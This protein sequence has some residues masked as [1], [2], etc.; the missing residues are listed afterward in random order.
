MAQRFAGALDRGAKV[1]TFDP[2]LSNTAARSTRWIPVKPATDLAVILAMCREIVASELHDESMIEEHTNT[3]VDALKDHLEPYTLEWAARES[4]VP[5]GRIRSLAVEYGTTKPGICVSFRGA[6][7]HH[8]GVQTQRAIYL[9]QALT[10]NLDPG[11]GM[12][13]PPRWRYPFAFPEGEPKNLDVFNGEP[14]AYSY[15]IYGVSHQILSMID[16]GPERP[17]IYMTYCHNP[18]YANGDCRDNERVFS[19][20]EKIPFLVAIDVTLSETSLLADLVL[21]DAT[22]LERWTCDGRPSPE[23]V[24]EYQLRQPMHPPRGEA[25]NFCDVA[26]QL[27]ERL[28]FEI[29]FGTAEEFV[30]ETCNATPGVKEAGGFEYMRAHGLWSDPDAEPMKVPPRPMEL[31]S[32][33]LAEAGFSALPGW[34]AA[35]E[36]EA[37]ADDELVLITFK[38]AVQTHSRTQ[39]CKWLTEL[40]HSNPAWIHPETAAARGIRNGDRIVVRSE[41]G[42]IVTTARVT[43]GIH[44]GAI[45]VSHHCGHWGHGAYAS[46][47][48]SHVH[49][50]EPDSRLKWWEDNGVHPNLIIPNRGD[51]IAGAMC[52]NDTVVTVTKT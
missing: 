51:P 3:T 41:V 24:P 49:A 20:E 18:V 45:A 30:R 1:Y 11:G 44:P 26:C 25:R 32:E 14:G 39:G 50:A 48:T 8:N 5:A 29:G 13:A 27:A 6:F 19:D 10:G 22:Y 36:H 23:G 34:M 31:V 16:R 52:W 42:E 4:G 47:E 9:L 40:H 35:P 21:P 43:E 46:G 28:G 12:G 15:P 38:V 33:T 37:M 17:S 2:R 7:M